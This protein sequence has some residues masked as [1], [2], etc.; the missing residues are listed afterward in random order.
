MKKSRLVLYTL[1]IL[2]ALI[3]IGLM[4]S[5]FVLNLARDL[6]LERHLQKPDVERK[7]F[8]DDLVLQIIED[9]ETDHIFQSLLKIEMLEND[10]KMGEGIKQY[11]AD[12]SQVVIRNLSGKKGI[13]KVKPKPKSMTR[14]ERTVFTGS[15]IK[16][17]YTVTN[18]LLSLHLSKAEAEDRAK[19]IPYYVLTEPEI[20]RKIGSQPYELFVNNYCLPSG[21]LSVKDADI[22]CLYINERLDEYSSKVFD[23]K[24]MSNLLLEVIK[25]EKLFEN[26]LD[27][28]GNF[29]R[30]I[31]Y[32][33]TARKF[34]EGRAN[35]R[36]SFKS[37]PR[38]RVR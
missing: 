36:L 16:N 3:L 18:Y 22:V 34:I 32:V 37:F 2:G 8:A 7:V 31:N 35:G 12:F 9:A 14:E 27:A 13:K 29:L 24:D 1:E 28:D 23:Y 6:S 30:Q 15:L 19:V 4:L 17:S 26:E 5:F 25:L 11:F 20:S 10:E 33:K 21:H 38:Y